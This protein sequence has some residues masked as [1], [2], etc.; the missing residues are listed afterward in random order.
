MNIKVKL[1]KTF[2]Y[3]GSKLRLYSSE[4]FLDKQEIISIL[5][6][7]NWKNVKTKQIVYKRFCNNKNKKCSKMFLNIYFVL[8]NNKLVLYFQVH[9]YCCFIE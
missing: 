9:I 8:K 7:T 3:I 2:N 1:P 4:S 5:E 6:N